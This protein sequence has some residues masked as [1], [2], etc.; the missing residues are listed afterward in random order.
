MY[1]AR[2]AAQGVEACPGDALMAVDY[3]AL[4]FPKSRV[5]ALEK[6]D[7]AAA[8]ATQDKKESAKAKRR[9]KGMCEAWSPCPVGGFMVRCYRKDTQTHHLISGIGRR[10]KGKSILA[11]HKLRICDQCHADIHAKVLQPTTDTTE[12]AKVRYRRQK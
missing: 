10:N 12:A 11:E 5:K 8:L 6:A 7:K 1:Y 9:A 3:S 4:K 2:R